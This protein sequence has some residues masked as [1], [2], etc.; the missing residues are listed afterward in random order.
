MLDNHTI[1]VF[2]VD[3]HELVRIGVSSFLSNQ[4]GIEVIGQA[5]SGSEAITQVA[6][7]KPDIMV[8]DMQMPDMS[9]LELIQKLKAMPFNSKYIILSGFLDKQTILDTIQVGGATGYLLKSLPP[10]KLVEAIKTVYQGGNY[11]SDKPSQILLNNYLDNLKTGPSEPSEPKVALL[12]KREQE[13]LNLIAQDLNNQ[14][15][16][17][18]LFISARTAS[19]H[20]QN[21]MNKLDIHTSQGLVRYAFLNGLVAI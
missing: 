20:R 4:E 1:K 9:G 3:D 2:L 8:I 5:C 7:L 12:T 18:K 21:I 16:G 14:E 15:I 13:I 17:E 10:N 11:F 19:T 6:D